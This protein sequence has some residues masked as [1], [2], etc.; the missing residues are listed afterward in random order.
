[1]VLNRERIALRSRSISGF[2]AV[3]LWLGPAAGWAAA[4]AEG[5]VKKNTWW[6][7]PRASAEAQQVDWLFTLIFVITGI[8]FIGVQGVLVWF[9]IKYRH[10][11]G[12]K[13][14]FL[15]GHHK[16]EVVWT[17][18]P[19]LILIFLGVVSIRIWGELRMQ[20]PDPANGPITEVAV[21]AQQF[22]W[23]IR[24]PGEDGVLGTRWDIGADPEYPEKPPIVSIINV[25][26]DRPVL[27]HL[28]S[29]D[30]LHSFFLPNM[31]VKLDAVPGLT[32]RL[33][34]TPTQVGQYELVCA[35]LCGPQHYS[36]RGLLIVMSQEDYD[37]WLEQQY[38]MIYDIVGDD[39]DYDDDDE[40]DEE[41][42]P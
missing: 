36:M 12:R 13:A 16:A 11:P 35:E 26:V 17:A 7:P 4:Q 3:L 22:A 31:R 41:E 33:W 2:L 6:L 27:V 19:A 1:M 30:V 29:R 32:G 20:A 15:H 14:T 21:E 5:I 34:F 23:N 42:E 40:E 37:A 38:D 18:A 9:L 28:T 8:V 39:E 25:P 10:R 24:Y